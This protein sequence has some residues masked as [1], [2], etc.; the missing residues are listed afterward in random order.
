MS[1]QRLPKWRIKIS[2]TQIRKAYRDDV[3]ARF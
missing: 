2:M 3:I 1:E